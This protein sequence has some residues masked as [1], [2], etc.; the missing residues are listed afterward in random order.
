MTSASYLSKWYGSQPF[1]IGN[2]VSRAN[3]FRKLR[4]P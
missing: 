4:I 2:G 1:R 3:A